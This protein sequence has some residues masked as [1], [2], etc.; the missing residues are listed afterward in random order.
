MHR[1][2]PPPHRMQPQYR[3]LRFGVFEDLKSRSRFGLSLAQDGAS[4]FLAWSTG[5]RISNDPAS[6]TAQ[7]QVL[8]GIISPPPKDRNFADPNAGQAS[9]LPWKDLRPQA[10]L[11][12]YIAEVQ[13]QTDLGITYKR[14]PH[15]LS[16]SNPS[17]L[18]DVTSRHLPPPTF[19]NPFFRRFNPNKKPMR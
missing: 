14:R 15:P 1:E 9:R 8:R 7:P 12:R 18:Q 17:P 13:K 11:L 10:G 3:G 2:T 5:S 4:F 19:R 16:R 6:I